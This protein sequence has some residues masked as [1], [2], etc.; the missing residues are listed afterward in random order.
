MDEKGFVEGVRRYMSQLREEKRYSSAK[1]YQDA[2]NSF[3]KYSGTEN[4]SYSD[5]NKANLHRYEAYL[6]E[7]GCMCNT[8]ST[9]MRR[10][11][12]VYNKAIEDGD[13]EYIPGLFQG[14]FTGVESKRKKSLSLENQHK[15]MTVKVES[16]VLRETQLVVCLLFQYA[17]MSFVDFAH[18]KERNIKKQG[19][20]SMATNNFA[21]KGIVDYNRQKTGTPMRLEILDTAELM[22]K[23][24]MGDKRPASG[25]LFPFLSGTKT[26]YEAYLEYNAAL[27]RFN[28]NLKALKKAAGIASDVTSYTIRHSFAMALK[29]QN[30][31]IEM[32]SELLGHKSIKTTQIYLRSFSLE[33]MTEV[34]STCFGCVYNYVSKVG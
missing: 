32:I 8:V 15:L 14:V 21:E 28:R 23:E 4:I 1:S 33:K 10:I 11:R 25:Y 18:L 17:G 2:L 26:G 19:G 24:L 30:V 20:T 12:C 3:I 6:L 13:A 34:N 9:Y 5:I 7:K 27:S 31:P 29:E 16:E 22:R